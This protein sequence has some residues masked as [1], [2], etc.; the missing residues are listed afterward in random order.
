MTTKRSK[1][2]AAFTI[3]EVM[4]AILILSVAV[5]GA[6][7]YRYY[8]ALD[9]RKAAMQATAARIGLLLCES[10]RGLN[11]IETYNPAAYFGSDLVIAANPVFD[12][13]A[14]HAITGPIVN[15]SFTPLGIYSIVADGA[16]YYAILSWKDINTDL[17]ALNVVIAWELRGRGVTA[18]TDVAGLKL[19][20]LTTYTSS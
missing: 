15:E 7:G 9:A 3:I 6:S 13:S 4:V 12:F 5:I 16:T 19:F 8:A 11:G 14:G 2:T 18:Q 20:E 10:W 17:R 1:S